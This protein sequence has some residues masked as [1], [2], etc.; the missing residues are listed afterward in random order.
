MKLLCICM[1]QRDTKLL[2][3]LFCQHFI[4]HQKFME[5][6]TFILSTGYRIP[7][8]EIIS[9]FSCVVLEN[10]KNNRNDFHLLHC[11]MRWIWFCASRPSSNKFKCTSSLLCENRFQEIADAGLRQTIDRWAKARLN[12]IYIL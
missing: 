1:Q 4:R 6:F 10:I 7:Q 11:T 2:Q 12:T 5:N 8:S 9:N 3:V